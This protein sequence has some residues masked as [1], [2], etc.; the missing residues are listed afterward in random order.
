MKAQSAFFPFGFGVRASDAYDAL[1]VHTVICDRY[2]CE[3]LIEGAEI[4]EDHEDVSWSIYGHLT[5]QG[6]ECIGDFI[7]FEAACEIA[8]KITGAHKRQDGPRNLA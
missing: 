6:L 7:S 3:A 8:M 1:E 5:G 4:P 2:S